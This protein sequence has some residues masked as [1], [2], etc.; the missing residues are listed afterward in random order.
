MSNIFFPFFLKVKVCCFCFWSIFINEISLSLQI[1]TNNNARIH[2][3]VMQ[4]TNEAIPQTSDHCLIDQLYYKN[5]IKNIII[6]K[7]LEG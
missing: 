5:A 4:K 1:I 2:N 6:S 3:T 7:T